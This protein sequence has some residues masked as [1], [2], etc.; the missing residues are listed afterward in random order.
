[1]QPHTPPEVEALAK[2]KE[3]EA[4]LSATIALLWEVSR[5]RPAEAVL[6]NLRSEIAKI[7]RNVRFLRDALGDSVADDLDS[8][9]G[10]D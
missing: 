5:A 3:L 9:R 7:E 2:L 6:H 10:D 8:T 1:M 4:L